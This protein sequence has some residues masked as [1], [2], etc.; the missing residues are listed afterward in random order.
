[1]VEVSKACAPVG[2][3]LAPLQVG[4]QPTLSPGTPQLRGSP[5][6]GS[7]LRNV[8][9]SLLRK[10]FSLG[11]YVLACLPLAI[12]IQAPPTSTSLRRVL[13]YEKSSTAPLD[14]AQD[15]ACWCN[16]DML[17][18]GLEP[19]QWDVTNETT[20][21]WGNDHRVFHIQ[22]RHTSMSNGNIS[23]ALDLTIMLFG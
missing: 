4:R 14:E 7:L 17:R 6:A 11:V 21:R 18:G 22:A 9:G 1:M 3:G 8:A 13:V 10:A 15:N 16:Y 23:P 12:F 19:F 5:V 2:S 20:R